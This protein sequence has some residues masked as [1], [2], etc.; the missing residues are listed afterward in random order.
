VYHNLLIPLA[1]DGAHDNATALRTAQALAENGARFTLMH[2]IETIPVY[3]T[4]YMP[5]EI[6]PAR[7]KTVARELEALGTT[8]PNSSIAIADGR[9]GWE[10]CNWAE[11][12]GCDCIV[13]SAHVPAFSD[14]LL[15]SAANVVVRHAKC[16]VHLM[17]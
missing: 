14:I 9:P 11:K 12:N 10:I 2:V 16:A 6:L 1:L 17:H 4:E 8:L 15:G 3:V 5:P 7:R 13:I